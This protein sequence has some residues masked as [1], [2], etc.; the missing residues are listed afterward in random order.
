[1]GSLQ[2]GL[3]Y[4][5]FMIQD[6]FGDTTGGITKNVQ[7]Y[8]FTIVDGYPYFRRTELLLLDRPRRIYLVFDKDGRH[9]HAI[10][11][12]LEKDVPEVLTLVNICRRDLGVNP[13]E[14]DFNLNCRIEFDDKHKKPKRLEHLP[15]DFR[16]VITSCYTAYWDHSPMDSVEPNE[17]LEKGQWYYIPSIRQ[18]MRVEHLEAT[19]RRV[20]STKEV[21]RS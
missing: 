3:K 13:Q 4:A 9:Y 7:Y 20:Y 2:G 12:D 6:P 8:P 19:K 10:E 1:M 16:G 15:I 17:L 5:M 11:S 21:Q 18:R 14:L